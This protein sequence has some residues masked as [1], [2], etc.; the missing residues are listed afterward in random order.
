MGSSVSVHG[1]SC[2]A[3]CEIL[4]PWSKIEPVSPGLE[5]GLLTTGPPVVNT[6]QNIL[7]NIQQNVGNTQQNILMGTRKPLLLYLK[8]IYIYLKSIK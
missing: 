5:G 4:V 7:G 3:A 2:S 6:Q 8:D 1:L